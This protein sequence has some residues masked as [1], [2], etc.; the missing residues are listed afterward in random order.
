LIV[1][2]TTSTASTFVAPALMLCFWRRATAVGTMASMLSGAGT[3]LALSITGAIVN[4]AAFE[5]PYKLLGFEPL[6]WGL[7]VSAVTGVLVSLVT[8]PPPAAL[9]SKMFDVQPTERVRAT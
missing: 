1:F 8:T 4:G 9:V 5:Q 3:I 6:V 2:S 7:A